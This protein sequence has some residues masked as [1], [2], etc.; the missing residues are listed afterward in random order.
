MLFDWLNSLDQVKLLG[1]V[2]LVFAVSRLARQLDRSRGRRD[3]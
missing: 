2:I 1:L 3:A